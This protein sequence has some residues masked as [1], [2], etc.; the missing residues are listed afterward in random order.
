MRRIALA[1]VLILGL[2]A[3]GDDDDTAEAPDTTAASEPSE[4]PA[5]DQVTVDIADFAFSPREIEVAAGQQLVWTNGDDFAHTAQG[6]D[7]A[8]D[9]GEIGPGATSA[10]VTFDE[11]GMYSYICGIHNSM[12][13]TVTV[14]A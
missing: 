3:C 2:A 5:T 9:T 6:D 7:D 14:S 12:T 1:A 8:F 13:G 10:P 11:P 4:A